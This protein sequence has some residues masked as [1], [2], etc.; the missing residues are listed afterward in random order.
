MIFSFIPFT[1]GCWNAASGDFSSSADVDSSIL[2]ISANFKSRRGLGDLLSS[3]MDSIARLTNL[4]TDKKNVKNQY[5]K[6]FKDENTQEFNFVQKFM[7][8]PN[9]NLVH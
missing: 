3:L 8:I 4:Y 2:N 9:L 6:G 7:S 1:C 5:K